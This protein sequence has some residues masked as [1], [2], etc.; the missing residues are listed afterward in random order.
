MGKK[1]SLSWAEAKMFSWEAETAKAIEAASLGDGLL[2][3]D[4]IK[5][6]VKRLIKL[7]KDKSPRVREAAAGSL[8]K[9]GDARA[10]KPLIRVLKDKDENVR[11]AAKE[12]LEKI[13][14][15]G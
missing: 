2:R 3:D 15:G 5:V 13:R 4:E 10:I 8:G 14:E 12:A 6:A 9:R 7:L 11:E 1:E